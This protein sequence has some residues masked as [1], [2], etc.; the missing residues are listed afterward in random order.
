M[1]NVKSKRA[2]M[3]LGAC[4]AVL[5][6]TF[7]GMAVTTTSGAGTD[8]APAPTLTAVAT[9]A[10]TPAASTPPQSP[11]EPPTG[12]A[13]NAY[14]GDQA[15]AGTLPSAGYGDTGSNGHGLLLLVLAGSI[16]AAGTALTIAG[17]LPNSRKQ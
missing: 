4:A 17:R 15:G 14:T 12:A 7:A 1:L 13:G 11:V 3:T 9:A 8:T 6:L 5:A 2:V 16:L 10:A